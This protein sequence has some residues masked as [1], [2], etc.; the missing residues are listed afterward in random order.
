MYQI[1]FT[2]VPSFVPSILI[3]SFNI[4]CLAFNSHLKFHY[5]PTIVRPS[6]SNS[7]TT[8]GV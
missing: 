3:V 8:L 7:V 5:I 6:M 2:V 4:G 1:V